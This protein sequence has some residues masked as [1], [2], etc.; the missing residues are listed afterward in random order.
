MS[1]GSLISVGGIKEAVWGTG[2]APTFFPPVSSEGFK[3]G[4]EAISELQLRGILDIDPKYKGMQMVSGAFGGIVYPSQI[5]HLLRAALGP[6]VTTAAF[7]HTFTPLQAPFN[8][9][10]G[11]A[12]P[13][14]SFTIN[15][16]T[17]Q[18]I[19]YEG[20]QCSKLGFKFS[21]GGALTYDSSW[22]GRDASAQAAP[23]VTLPTDTPFTLSANIQRNAVAFADL[24]DFSLDISNSLEAVKTINNSDKIA[25]ISWSGRRT[26]NL[27]GTADFASTQLYTDFKAF[28][29]TPWTITFTA[30][31]SVLAF[32][33]PALLLTD[34]SNNVGGD[35]RITASFSS[36][37]QY[38]IATARAFRALLTNTI[39]GY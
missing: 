26:V 38:D 21:Q 1:V 39:S 22:V 7:L 31:A 10:L 6:P 27:S 17:T 5:G 9:G 34:E 2:L 15:R 24:Q 8:A 23:T 19:R 35:G 30:G 36:E 4:P 18:I 28:G 37:A 13:S 12:L 25:R 29:N 32:E 3:D 11:Q 33:F 16:D 14:Y 20:M